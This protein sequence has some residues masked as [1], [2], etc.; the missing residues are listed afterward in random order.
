M[1]RAI[2]GMLGT[3]PAG[4]G[5]LQ[6]HRAAGAAQT[7]GSWAPAAVSLAAP[8]VQ[9]GRLGADELRAEALVAVGAVHGR[10]ITSLDCG[11]SRL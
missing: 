3:A 6:R 9:P 4:L 11:A 8:V 1:K 7:P 10:Y 5:A 2:Q